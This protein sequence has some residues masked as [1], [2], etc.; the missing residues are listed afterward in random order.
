M[1]CNDLSRPVP[2]TSQFTAAMSIFAVKVV[3]LG[4]K[5]CG[6]TALLQR[7]VMGRWQPRYDPTFGCG[8]GARLLALPDGSLAS[9]GVWDTSGSPSFRHLSKLYIPGADAAVVVFDPASCASLEAAL[10]WAAEA[11]RLQRGIAVHLAAS[12]ADLRACVVSG[13][14]DGRLQQQQKPQQRAAASD[15]AAGQQRRAVGP[16][17]DSSPSAGQVAD[18]PATP[19]ASL[20][21]LRTSSIASTRSYETEVVGNA[22]HTGSSQPCSGRSSAA[23]S[24]PDLSGSPTR[25]S[26]DFGGGQPSQQQHQQV[27]P[28]RDSCH[29][30][31]WGGAQARDS[32]RPQA[33]PLLQPAVQLAALRAEASAL[34]AELHEGVSSMTGLGVGELFGTVAAEA[35]QRKAAAGKEQP[36]APRAPETH[37][38]SLPP[39]PLHAPPLP[40]LHATR[41]AARART[42]SGSHEYS[43]PGSELLGGYPPTAAAGPQR[44]H[45]AH[46]EQ[47]P[48]CRVS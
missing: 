16:E 2:R 36:Q 18:Q 9:V 35:M 27:R 7:F 19:F 25:S 20:A 10:A 31:F 37:Q 6:K 3:L 29:V 15:L 33:R 4:D 30:S 28:A 32:A 26:G 45:P 43:I 14:V 22:G 34:R 23:D 44:R 5:G 11:R 39:A 48:A 42:D 21:Q 13:D 40:G 1:P 24:R 12:K 41:G 47:P 46:G 8:F 17:P 38:L